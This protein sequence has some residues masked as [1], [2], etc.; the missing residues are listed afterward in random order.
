MRYCLLPLLASLLLSFQATAQR[1][2]PQDEVRLSDGSSVTGKITQVGNDQLTVLRPDRSTSVLKW[3]NIDTVMGLRHS[4]WAFSLQIG[5]GRSPY[6]SIFE[7]RAFSP[8][9]FNVQLKIGK[10]KNLKGFRYFHYEK[11]ASNPDGIFKIG[12]GMEH[13]FR[14]HYLRPISLSIGSTF[15]A[16]KV[17]RNNTPQLSIEPYSTVYWKLNEQILMTGQLGL[18]Y[19]F[20]SKNKQLGLSACVGA[21]Y[22]L[23]NFKRRYEFINANKRFPNRF[24]HD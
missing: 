15:N 17:Q 19:N 9:A 12:Y 13:F 22:L 24:S 6:F 16:L 18:Q 4:T 2:L 3:A 1:R 11:V 20:L 10:M 8:A 23:R 5:G 7:N 21:T 14:G